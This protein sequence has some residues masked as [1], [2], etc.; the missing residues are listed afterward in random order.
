MSLIPKN[1]KN[2]YALQKENQGLIK[3]LHWVKTMDVDTQL[4]GNDRPLLLFS[5]NTTIWRFRG[6]LALYFFYQ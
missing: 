2:E 3:S 5:F 6:G 1:S 4:Q